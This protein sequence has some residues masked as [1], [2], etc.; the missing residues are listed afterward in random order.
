[1]KQHSLPVEAQW[2][3]IRA[4]VVAD[5]MRPGRWRVVSRKRRRPE[6]SGWRAQRSGRSRSRLATNS[7]G[8]LF[9]ISH[10]AGI[11]GQEHLQRLNGL[12]LGEAELDDGPFVVGFDILQCAGR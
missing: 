2:E 1:M 3:M 4:W 10:G 11:A 8:L 7:I 6:H 5:C 12:P 9:R